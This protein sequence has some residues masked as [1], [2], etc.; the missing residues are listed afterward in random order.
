MLVA[1]VHRV[2][3]VEDDAA[4]AALLA[5]FVRAIGMIA[6]V[7]SSLEEVEAALATGPFCCVLLDRQIPF[8]AGSVALTSTGDA[9]QK[10]IRALDPR[11]NAADYHVLPILVVS[12]AVSGLPATRQAAFIST[13]LRD[14][15]TSYIPKPFDAETVTGEILAAL[16]R[17]G[18]S[19][20]ASCAALAPPGSAAPSTPPAKEPESSGP[21]VVLVLDGIRAGRRMT[22][23]VNRKRR[24]LQDQQFIAVLR[25]AAERR[26]GS[27][28]YLPPRELGVTRAPGIPS[29]VRAA[30]A[31]AVPEGFSI[32]QRSEGNLRLHPLVSVE[33]IAWEVF[34]KD[35]NP[36][37]QA[38]AAAERK[39]R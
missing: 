1:K 28:A 38:V 6:Y 15:G 39:R 5:D 19:D 20:H 25:L 10:R 27:E 11:R 34:E 16:D 7:A 37:I 17:A 4:T 33:S 36:V 13:N 9:A 14:G 30:V 3:I 35:A 2:L 26:R 23:L 18:R 32:L 8:A 29:Q 31:D 21:L 12:G 24:D 22:F